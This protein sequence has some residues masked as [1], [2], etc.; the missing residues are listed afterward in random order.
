MTVPKE[1]LIMVNR[2]AILVFDCVGELTLQPG[3]MGFCGIPVN[4]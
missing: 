1:L 2:G 4:P 3:H